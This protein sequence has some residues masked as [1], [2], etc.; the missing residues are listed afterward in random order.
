MSNIEHDDDE[1]CIKLAEDQMERA[2]SALSE[3]DNPRVS[4]RIA[5]LLL[6]ATTFAIDVASESEKNG[7]GESAAPDESTSTTD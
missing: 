1:F 7:D 3:L 2:F 4:T 6:I 5:Q